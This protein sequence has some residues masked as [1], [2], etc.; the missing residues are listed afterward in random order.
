MLAVIPLALTGCTV[1]IVSDGDVNSP[2]NNKA[3]ECWNST[4]TRT[5]DGFPS[6]SKGRT[7]VDCT[8][9][10]ELETFFVDDVDATTDRNTAII[11]TYQ[12]CERQA[13]QLLGAPRRTGRIEVNYYLTEKSTDGHVT[14]RVACTLAEAKNYS[15]H[16]HVRRT[17]SLRGALTQPGPLAIG[18]V[19]VAYGPEG[20]PIDVDYLPNCDGPHGGE[21]TGLQRFDPA[22]LPTTAAEYKT[23]AVQMCE[24]SVIAYLGWSDSRSST[25]VNPLFLGPGVD[26]LTRGADMVR[27]LVVANNGKHFTGVVK[28]IGDKPVP[29]A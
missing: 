2:S 3:G 15:R 17:G 9:E 11:N 6:T 24:K 4:A 19:Q 8:A 21:F 12:L 29:I 25:D 28:G 7:I 23:V 10:H 22:A 18:C 27:C 13:D 16:E 20:T 1:G 14:R 5:T 26:A